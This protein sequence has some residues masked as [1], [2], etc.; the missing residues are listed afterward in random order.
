MFLQWAP[1]HHP[2]WG[3]ERCHIYHYGLYIHLKPLKGFLAIVL[4]KP[5]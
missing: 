1:C 5:K 4:G 2:R 3:F